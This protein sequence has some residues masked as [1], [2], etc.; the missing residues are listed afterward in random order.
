V[1]GDLR[2]MND[3]QIARTQAKMREIIKRNSPGTAADIMFDSG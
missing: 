3:G 1:P 2:A